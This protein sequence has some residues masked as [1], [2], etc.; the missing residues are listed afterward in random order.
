MLVALKSFVYSCPVIVQDI[1][2]DALLLDLNN[3]AFKGNFFVEAG[4]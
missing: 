3:E 4:D 2:F 1:A